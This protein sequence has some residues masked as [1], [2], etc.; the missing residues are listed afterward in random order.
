[1]IVK[2]LHHNEDAEFDETTFT[3]SAANR[4]GKR[5]KITKN[6][7]KHDGGNV[8]GVPSREISDKSLLHIKEYD[9]EALS[10]DNIVRKGGVSSL[11]ERCEREVNMN[12][13]ST[14]N[15]KKIGGVTNIRRSSI[16][17]K[18]IKPVSLCDTETRRGLLS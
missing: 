14:S 7:S 18:V 8:R 15:D 1:M 13:E 3:H 16:K 17:Y 4:G 10:V 5:N 9:S 2:T 6:L 12:D 11:Q